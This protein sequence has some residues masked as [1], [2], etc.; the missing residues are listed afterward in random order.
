MT[1]SE[2]LR[3][4]RWQKIRLKVFERDEWKCQRRDCKSPENTMLVV[5]HREYR[6]KSDPWEY[7]LDW[8][9]T[10]CKNCHD[11]EHK[12]MQRTDCSALSHKAISPKKVSERNVVVSD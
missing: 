6:L 4:P 7:P 2:K 12:L 11:T 10:Y 9:I 1:Y 3:D 5:H 8:L